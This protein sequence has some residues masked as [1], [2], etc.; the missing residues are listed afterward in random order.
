MA[1]S[2]EKQ[3]VPKKGVPYVQSLEKATAVLEA[4]KSG[5]RELGLVEIMRITGLDK[6]AVQRLTHTWRELGY[7]GKDPSSKRY[8]L[9]PK[10]LD[11]ANSFLSTSPLVSHALPY[12]VE[13]RKAFDVRVGLA[14]RMGEQ[15]MF[16]I[17]LQSNMS[18]FDTV[19][20]GYRLLL[21]ATASGRS[22]LSLSGDDELDEIVEHMRVEKVTPHTIVDRGEIKKEI[23]RAREFGFAFTNQEHSHGALNVAAAVSSNTGRAVGAI[24]ALGYTSSWEAKKLI[25][26][27]A[28]EI[29]QAAQNLTRDIASYSDHVL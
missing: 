9:T 21:L 6:S 4:F 26:Q 29:M 16:L 17:P 23:L 14:T 22:M 25:S 1:T 11:V 3:K 5:S 2:D 8:F 13:L 27:V 12:V 20:P 7:L 15:V 24:A 18:S 10:V 28:P 19:H